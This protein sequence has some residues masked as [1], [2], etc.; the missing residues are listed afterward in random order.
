LA[1][2]ASE[3]GFDWTKIQDALDKAEEELAEVRRVL[4]VEPACRDRVEEEIGDLLF[5]AGDLARSLGSDPESC[6]RRANR[7]FGRRFR[8]LEQEVAKRGKSVRECALDELK[9][10]WNSAKS[11]A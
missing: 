10:I 2:L 7:E 8:R 6:L 1:L 3:A 5:A 9:G 11:G 4:A